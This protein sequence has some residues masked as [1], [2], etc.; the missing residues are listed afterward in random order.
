MRKTAILVLFLYLCFSGTSIVHGSPANTK[1]QET[2]ASSEMDDVLHNPEAEEQKDLKNEK[3]PDEVK[4]MKDMNSSDVSEAPGEP[5]ETSEKEQ[6]DE[7]A[8]DIGLTY[9]T[10]LQSKGWIGFKAAGEVSGFPESGLRMESVEIATSSDIGLRYGVH[11]QGMGWQ[12]E[13]RSG[14][15]AGTTGE[16]KRIEA[17]WIDMDEKTKEAYDILYS[18]FVEGFGWLDWAKNG[19]RTGSMGLARRMESI[20]IKLVPKEEVADYNVRN[21]LLEEKEIHYTAHMEKLGWRNKPESQFY[22]RT[23]GESLRLE[24]LNFEKAIDGIEILHTSHVSKI[25]WSEERSSASICGTTGMGL[26]MEAI[27][28]RLE[29]SD[30]YEVYYRVHVQ[31]IG[32]MGWTGNGKMAG[33]TGLGLRIEAIEIKVLPKGLN[34]IK[35]DE[36]R[37]S[38]VSDQVGIEYGAHVQSFGWMKVVSDGSTAGTLGLDKRMEGFTA[39]VKNNPWLQVS[40]SALV[41][42]EGWQSSVVEKQVAGTTGQGGAIEAVRFELKG[43]L[44]KYYDILYRVYTPEAGW[45]GWSS[46]GRPN[47]S[48][49]FEQIIEAMEVLIQPKKMKSEHEITNPFRENLIPAAKKVTAYYTTEAS[50]LYSAAGSDRILSSIPRSVFLFGRV[51]DGYWLETE[52]KGI[53]GYVRMS[54]VSGHQVTAAGSTIIVNK[55]HG[56]PSSFAPGVNHDANTALNSMVRAAS[57]IGI[58]LNAY[59]GYRSYTY[60]STLF[61]RYVRR[62]GRA[63]AETYSM[64]PGFSEHQTGL[65][66]DIGG[67]DS[68]MWTSSSFGRTTEGIW[69]RENAHRF[70]FILRYPDKKLPVTGIKYEPWHFRYVGVELAEEIRKSGKTLDEYFDVVSPTY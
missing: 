7:E 32:W 67:R 53:K 65:S 12:G 14:E 10:H 52:Y 55:G 60:Q 57:S 8:I 18:V 1:S 38:L 35:V 29:G 20:R 26:S 49:G 64:R 51:R 15:I 11:V 28:L 23:I 2:D 37:S 50:A 70:G 25:G 62:D 5:D 42:G 59:S 30:Y 58:Q 36:K 4:N 16:A 46:N 21:L 33:T 17:I 41:S 6:N 13:R 56:L 19:A 69:L 63:V 48:N 45:L 68:S 24:A 66:F 47:G 34:K 43:S 39:S 3:G 61:N 9:R 54:Q 27:K 31:S 22:A 44:A 40:Y